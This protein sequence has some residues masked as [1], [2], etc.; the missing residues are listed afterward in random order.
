MVLLLVP[1]IS[2]C[3]PP[4]LRKGFPKSVFSVTDQEMTVLTTLKGPLSFANRPAGTGMAVLPYF[5]DA[6][7]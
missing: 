6:K 2:P 5:C 1:C 7:E 4:K 3:L